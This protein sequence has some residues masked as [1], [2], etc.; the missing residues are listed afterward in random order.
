MVYDLAA[1]RRLEEMSAETNGNGHGGP[2]EWIPPSTREEA[3]L[4]I[5]G[6]S[7][8]IG[9]ILAQLAEDQAAWCERTGRTPA[10]YA[11]WRRRALFAKVHKESQLRECKRIRGHFLA[12]A[13][14]DHEGLRGLE[15]DAFADLLALCREAVD[16]WLDD[17]ADSGSERLD[18]ALTR[19]AASVDGVALTGVSRAGRPWAVASGFDSPSR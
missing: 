6:L 9:L 15:R 10:D 16:A 19:V 5:L 17:G 12:G 18:A 8:D 3:D 14:V 4:A 7:N 1:P 13:V 2:H 11:A